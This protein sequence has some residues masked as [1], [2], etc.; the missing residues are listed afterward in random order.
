MR[1][2]PCLAVMMAAATLTGCGPGKTDSGSAGS[3]QASSGTASE[4]D[5][6]ANR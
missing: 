4:L 5:S 6:P 3:T 2:L 1:F